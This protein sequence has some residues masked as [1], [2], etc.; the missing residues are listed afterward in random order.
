M[1]VKVGELW[2]LPIMFT[3]KTMLWGL[4]QVTLTFWVSV[5]LTVRWWVVLVISRFCPWPQSYD[6]LV[7]KSVSLNAK[8]FSDFPSLS[9]PTPQQWQGS[10]CS[11]HSPGEAA[12]WQTFNDLP[13]QSL[14]AYERARGRV[15]LKMTA[16]DMA[17]PQ[18]GFCPC[19][20][21]KPKGGA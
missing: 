13:S 5:S 21:T 4:W 16:C 20:K 18:L 12:A 7:L 9:L 17:V 2:I 15:P 14:G 1:D 11:C 10:G 8:D 19:C 6:S 3:K